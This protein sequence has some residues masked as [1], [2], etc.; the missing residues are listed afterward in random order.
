M[1]DLDGVPRHNERPVGSASVDSMETSPKSWLIAAVVLTLF[2]AFPGNRVTIPHQKDK[3]KTEEPFIVERITHE[4]GLDALGPVSPDGKSLVLI[5]HKPESTPNLYVMNLGDNS[6]R[7][8]TS[9]K[10]GAV[11]PA[12]SPDG[13]SIALTGYDET[14]NLSDIFTLEVK[15]N[16]LRKLTRNSFTD[17]EPVFLPDGKTL[18]YTTDE[19]PLPDAAF[20]ILHVASVPVAGGKGEFFTEDDVST[21]QPGLAPDGENVLLVKIAEASGRHSLWVYDRSGKPL[22]D[23]TGARLARVHRHVT[24][25]GSSRVLVWGQEHAEQHDDLFLLDTADGKLEPLP[26]PDLLKRAPS[27]SPDGRRIAFAGGASQ[28]RH[29]YLFEIETGEI[30]QLTF[31][32]NRGYTPVFISP[33][34]ILFGSDR[35]NTQDIYLLDL[36]RPT[37]EGKK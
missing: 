2:V 22:K 10:W 34:L 6:I 33:D 1:Y 24:I 30:K 26:E 13:L 12:W 31:K 5:A 23:L 9:L 17:K 16:R 35:D 4:M 7:P 25:P 20:G 21:I 37:P 14:S 11:E 27:V 32:G 18:L 8:V 36:T 3:K 15:T 19:S 29:V 28:G